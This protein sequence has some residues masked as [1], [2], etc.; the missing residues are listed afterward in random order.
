VINAQAQVDQADVAFVYEWAVDDQVLSAFTGASCHVPAT[1]AGKQLTVAVK[2][3]DTVAYKSNIVSEAIT[4]G[5]TT[6][7][8]MTMAGLYHDMKILGRTPIDNTGIRTS[9]PGSGFEI[10]V[11]SNGGD[12]LLGYSAGNNTMPY[13]CILVDGQQIDRPMFASN[14][15]YAIK[16]PA[17]EHTVTVFRDSANAPHV[18]CVLNYIEFDGQIL[19]KPANRELYIEVIGDSIACGLGSLGTYTPGV[20]WKESEHSASNSFGWYVA[21]DF[22]A[23]VS[24]IAKGGIGALK[25]VNDKTM[26]DIYSYVNGFAN[27]TPYDF[28]RKPDLVLVELGAND[29]SYDVSEFKPALEYIY[30]MILD[31]YGADTKILWVGK[32]QKFYDC[33]LELA[34][35]YGD[36]CHA[37][38]HKY[39]VSGSG[40]SIAAAAHPNAEEHRAYADAITQ[41]IKDNN[42]LP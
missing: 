4:V 28:A 13:F 22:N 8:K 5:D 15:V 26:V 11:N 24:I 3:V 25:A 16:V 27:Q 29:G 31:N 36:N 37:V 42:L 9:W 1:A 35:A 33:A 32:N 10:K 39:G 12:L 23:D 40:P 38:L 18:P 2:P 20:D 6:N 17:G 30:K 19:E 21:E 7:T 14:M 34:E 41:Y